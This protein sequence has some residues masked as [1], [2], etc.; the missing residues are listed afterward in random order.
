MGFDFSG[1]Y[2]V[3]SKVFIGIA[4]ID[5]VLEFKYLGAILG[6]DLK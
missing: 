6:H 5:M 3:I 1:T 4:P 2:E